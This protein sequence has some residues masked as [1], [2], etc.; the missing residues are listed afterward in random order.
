MTSSG[1]PTFLRNSRNPNKPT[2]DDLRKPFGV[3]EWVLKW[4]IQTGWSKAIAF[5]GANTDVQNNEATFTEVTLGLKNCFRYLQYVVPAPEEGWYVAVFHNYDLDEDGLINLNDFADIVTKYHN[6]HAQRNLKRHKQ[7]MQQI[8]LRKDPKQ[9]DDA[10]TA[11]SSPG[12]KSPLYDML[13]T[14][15]KECDALEDGVQFASHIVYPLHQG[16]C[17]VFKDYIFGSETGQGAFG[18]VQVVTHRATG[19]RRACKS[20]VVARARQW[21]L[22]NQEI[23]IMKQLNHPNILRLYEIYHDGYTVYLIVELCE[24]GQVFDRIVEH[25]EKLRMPITEKQVGIWM[26]EILSAIAYCHEKDIIHRDVK[27]E[28][29]LFVDKSETSPLKLIDF[30]LS[31]TAARIQDTQKE[32]IEKKSGVPGLV[33]KMM[34]KIGGKPILSANVKKIKMQRAGTPHYMAPEMIKGFYAHKC[35]TFAAGV[36]MHQL[37]TG[38]HPYYVPGVDDEKSVERKILETVPTAS[39]PEWTYVSGAAKDLCRSLLRRNPL[40]RPSAKEALQHPWFDQIKSSNSGMA[41]SLV[42][43]SVFEGLRSWQNQNKLKQAVVQL[44]AR[45]LSEKEIC[46]LRRKFKALDKQKDGMITLDEVRDAMREAGHL[47]V[48]ADLQAMF[49]SIGGAQG[50]ISWNEFLSALLCKRMMLQE[51]QLREIFRKFDVENTGRVSVQTLQKALKGTTKNG[52]LRQQELEEIFSEIDKNKDGYLDFYEF[53]ELMTPEQ[54]LVTG[55][56]V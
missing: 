19:V 42:S 29:I 41:T 38:I 53:V 33:A 16:A 31:S 39:G 24:G 14:H 9:E 4:L 52:H 8:A 56:K 47:V 12:E 49:A 2:A 11:T 22:M 10:T 36:I 13:N 35:D 17:Q 45:E 37:L 46:D 23:Q 32:E 48:E 27:P 44:I 21:E 6:H 54:F 18:K 26:T 43:A 28:N 50:R 51:S 1:S 34:P 3:A 20:V 55:K 5:C 40:K 30:G 25:Y 7:R 15:N